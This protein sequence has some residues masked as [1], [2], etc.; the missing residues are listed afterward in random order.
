MRNRPILVEFHYKSDA[1]Y[2]L[3]NKTH[4]PKGV[5]IDKQYNEDTEKEHRKLRPIL[6]AARK[7]ENYKGKCRMDGATLVIKGRNYTSSNLHQLPLE[8][9]GDMAPSISDEKNTIIGFF[10]ELNPL[11]NFH[12]S[13]FTIH[14]H[15]FHCSEQFIQHQKC[16]MFGDKETEVLVLACET[17]V[18]C[19]SLC[20]EIRNFDHEKWKQNAEASCTPGILAKFE[21]NLH[22]SKL[23]LSTEERKLVECCKDHDWGTGIPLHDPR[24]LDESQWHSQGLLGEKFCKLF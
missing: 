3:S 7:S 6:R 19:K 12:P 2:L 9:N 5:Y 4:L 15:R 14:G 24:A 20:R 16:L 18:E 8:I 11:S 22:L 21:Q 17:A 23:L 13:P 1:I 10:G